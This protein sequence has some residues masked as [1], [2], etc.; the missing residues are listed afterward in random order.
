MKNVKHDNTNAPAKIALRK[1]FLDLMNPRK[2]LE[3]YAGEERQ[4]YHACYQGYDVTAL[5]I[6]GGRGVKKIDNRRYVRDHADEYDFFD[7]DAYGSP[8][9]LLVTLLARRTNPAPFVVIVTDG[10]KLNLNYQ[11]PPHIIAGPARIPKTLAIPG[12]RRFH[13][14]LVHYLLRDMSTHYNVEFSHLVT[15]TG[16]LKNMA[17]FGFVTQ[18]REAPI[19]D[20][21]L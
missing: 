4:M 12:L 2:I 9:P 13:G 5:D 1:H 16:Q 10:T 8:Y 7:L 20:L 15:A 6:K 14:E 11:H 19:G 3:C 17:Y 18:K 21:R